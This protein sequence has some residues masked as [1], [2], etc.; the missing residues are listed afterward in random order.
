MKIRTLEEGVLANALFW[1]MITLAGPILAYLRVYWPRISGPLLYGLVGST[2]VAILCYVASGHSL[3]KVKTTLHNVESNLRNWSH[4][5]GFSV[6]KLE[7]SDSLFG[8]T[9]TLANGCP[10]GVFVLTKH[11][12]YVQ[13]RCQFV[14]SEEHQET[15]S[16]LTK[17]QSDVVTHRV[18]LELS[19]AKIPYTISDPGTPT[20]E[21]P[22]L[23]KL[24]LEKTVPISE[25][26]EPNFITCVN[27]MSSSASLAHSA[28]VLAFS[29]GV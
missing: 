20:G 11:P 10:L 2:C 28:A 24:V 15:L 1:I 6:K 22:R 21:V 7:F 4:D 16:K 26:T 8:L 5:L 13:F 25:L 23:Q 18:A 27:E 3:L 17:H 9:I 14:L 19:R 29:G 12:N